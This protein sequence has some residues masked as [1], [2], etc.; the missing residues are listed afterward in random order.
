MKK[1]P[2]CRVEVKII[3][4]EGFK[5]MQCPECKGHILPL[6]RLECI[7]HIKGLTQE[8]LK[9]EASAGLKNDSTGKVPCPKCMLPMKKE[10]LKIPVLTVFIDTCK[11]CELAWLD[12][13]ELALVQIA[14]EATRTFANMQEMKKRMETLEA[15]PER[16]RQLE[17]AIASLPDTTNP[18][19]EGLLEESLEEFITR[20]VFS[21]LIRK[22]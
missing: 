11:T 20:T 10:K 14:H 22:I 2:C 1:C 16:K 7:K 12:A 15:S 8:K 4:Y 6:S 5:I 13:G 19:R 18:F 9:A 21:A 17:D 3:P